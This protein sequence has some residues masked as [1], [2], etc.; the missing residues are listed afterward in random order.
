MH[1]T[2][3]RRLGTGSK[4]VAFGFFVVL[5]L[6]FMAFVGNAR[7][8]I[9]SAPPPQIW[10]DKADYAPGETVVLSGVNWAPGESV[11]IRV[12]DDAGQT[13]SR[14]VDVT[15]DASGAISDQFN[16]PDWFVALYTVTATGATGT[17]TTS[18]TDGNVKVR[19]VSGIHFDYKITSYATVNCTGPAIKATDTHTADTNGNSEGVGS[20]ESL[21]IEANSIANSPN[22]SYTF[23]HWTRPG[24]ASD[25]QV[26][27][28]PGFSDT[29]ATICLV[30]F[31]GNGSKDLF[32][33]YVAD[34]SPPVITKTISGTLGT[35]GWYTSNVTVAWTV[36]DAQSAVVI[37]S[38]CGTQSFT[39]DTS[40]VTSS[41]TAHSAGGSSSDSVVLKIDKT[42]PTASTSLD[43]VADHNGWYNA[44]VGWTTTGT[45]GTSGIASC[46]SGTYSGPDGTGL[47]VSGSCT[48][49]AGN[50]SGP[51]VSAAFKYDATAPSL[52]PTIA[53]QPI[54]LNGTHTASANAS[55][56]PSGVD[57]QSCGPV[58]TSS[59]GTKS[60]TCSATDNAGNTRSATVSY[61][62]SYLWSGFLQPINDTAHQ[63]G[64]A[65]SK[66]RLGQTIP[67]KF[68]IKNALGAVVQQSPNPTFS[69]SGNLGA[70]DANAVPET[71]TEVVTPDNGV[72]YS[73]DGNQY[74]Y[75]W[76]TKG[77]TAGEYRIYANLADG[78]KRYVDICLT[79]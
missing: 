17:A 24:S 11:H 73:W 9:E 44:A 39:S 40:S 51:A 69:R 78:S 12:N 3:D 72:T 50:G 42:N 55:D 22:G 66:F 71:I 58:V 57:S 54:L 41:C 19:S 74:H 60:L 29:D 4:A 70:C 53:P 30:G 67:A 15:A 35:N 52:N 64:V 76:S 8:G 36:T 34:S 37:D 28:A 26:V 65:E 25:P 59:V 7:A 1:S 20:S 43:R 38:G 5:A 32:G 45:D 16:L 68:V 56:S 23:D 18:F 79:K 13:W 2:S 61:V 75:N 77:L 10:S 46:S 62:V 49:N 33:H 31:S 47:T 6:T 48:D 63:T 27:L 14:D 21:K